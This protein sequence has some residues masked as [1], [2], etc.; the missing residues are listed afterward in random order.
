MNK[1]KKE[2]IENLKKFDDD[3][4]LMDGMDKLD[5]VIFG[6]MSILLKCTMSEFRPTA[7][8]D[9]VRMN[10]EKKIYSLESTLEKIAEK[11]SINSRVM[12][13]LS[14]IGELEAFESNITKYDEIDFDILNVYTPS[15]TLI[16]LTKFL[17]SMN[18]S[19]RDDLDDVRRVPE[20]YENINLDEFDEMLN[21]FVDYDITYHDENGLNRKILMENYKEFV[22]EIKTLQANKKI[23][24]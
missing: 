17:A 7:D 13:H 5:I 12:F 14:V 1:F 4:S 16:A 23:S 8:I 10:E 3:L 21:E 18:R 2:M 6:S 24:D 19:K 11:Y 22:E 20:I 15:P 9:V